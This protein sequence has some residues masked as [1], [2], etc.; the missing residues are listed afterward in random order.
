MS[1]IY[2]TDLDGTL[3]RN[4]A[5][6][7][8]YSREGIKQILDSGIDFTVASARSLTS[9]KYILSD[10][11]FSLPVIEHNGAYITDYKTEEHI[12]INSINKS[13]SE[14]VIELCNKYG[15]SPLISTY[16]VSRDKLCYADII[17]EGMELLLNNKKREGDKRLLKL[18][19]IKHALDNKIITF[20]IINKKEN[21]IDL[22]EVLKDKYGDYFSMTFEEDQYYPGW[23]WLVIT[24]ERATKA[25]AIETLLK[26]KGIH[27][28]EITVF[29]DSYN[30]IPMFKIAKNSIAVLNA[31]DE[32][33]EYST[34]I[35]GTNE[36]D[37]VVK[38]ILNNEINIL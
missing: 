20:T 18:E 12:V 14:E 26:I 22:Y 17:N 3:L 1:R 37:S 25:N 24:S 5:T 32:L 21:L 6:L 19:N 23:H 7:S 8:R 34:E 16:T 10:I 30:D 4:N 36:D 31:K 33:K 27:K 35:I 11:P 9:I 13:L 2:I 29:G 28:S 15:S 38:Y